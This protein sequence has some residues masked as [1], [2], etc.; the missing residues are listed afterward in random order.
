MKA[1]FL[2][3]KQSFELH[4]LS[5]PACPEDGLI[6]A[7]KV[8]GICGSDIRRWREGPSAGSAGTI[9][10]H[11]IAG[12]VV[13][14]G[15]KVMT[16][17]T[18]DRIAIAPDVHCGNCYYCR[19]GLYNLCDNLRLVG[20]TPDYPGGFAE[21]IVLTH[22]ILTN[23]IVHAM[24]AGLSFEAG[25]MAEPCCSVLASYDKAKTAPGDTVVVMGAGPIGCLHVAVA[26]SRGA[27]VIVSEPAEYRRRL[28]KRFQPEVIIDPYNED[29]HQAVLQ[30]TNEVGAD[31]VICA[32]PIATTHKQAVEIVR[33]GGKVILFGGLPPKNPLTTLD[34]N[35]IHYGE[36]EVLGSFSYHPAVHRLALDLLTAGTIDTNLLITNRFNLT[37]INKAFQ[38]AG[39]GEA[40]KVLIEFN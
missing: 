25:A 35:R 37:E 23:G 10:G 24:P 17:K 33:K 6:L 1:A 15:K 27:Q 5:E 7:V 36:I 34:G 32:N 30:H 20:I 8:C 2:T 4:D 13:Q 31:V 18:G 3:G 28:I 16:F 22:E 21:R 39:S 19:H 38:I 12:I 11:E 9:P 40:L 29:L 26:H 14:S